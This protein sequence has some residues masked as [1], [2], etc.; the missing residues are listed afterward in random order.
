VIIKSNLLKDISPTDLDLIKKIDNDHFPFPW[1]E[2][3][4][5]NSAENSN[6]LCFYDPKCRG[7][8]IYLLSPLEKLAHLLK[9]VTSPESRGMG[10]AA[11]I[12]NASYS[13]FRMLGVERCMLEVEVSNTSAIGLYLKQGYN[14]IHLQKKFYSNG[15]DAHIMEKHL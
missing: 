1:K 15:A 4:W 3:N 12:L 8:A 6:Y 14:K 7:F 9:V 11:S 2:T 13:H 10:I 5:H